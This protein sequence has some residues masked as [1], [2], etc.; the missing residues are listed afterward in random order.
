MRHP[1]VQNHPEIW[2]LAYIYY[3]YFSLKSGRK[4]VM[5]DLHMS[6]GKRVIVPGV[7]TLL[8]AVMSG[9]VMLGVGGSTRRMKIVHRCAIIFF[10]GM[11]YSI[12]GQDKLANIFRWDETWIATSILSAL[13]SIWVG[14]RLFASAGGSSKS[15]G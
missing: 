4:A 1:E 5:K 11:A 14:R 7:V 2:D 8:V 9:G 13:G 3:G 10:V 15:D 12:M 6:L